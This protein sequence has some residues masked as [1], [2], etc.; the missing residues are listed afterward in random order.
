MK[1]NKVVSIGRKKYSKE[2]ISKMADEFRAYSE[3]CRAQSA[4]NGM[5]KTPIEIKTLDERTII[6][7][8]LG[9]RLEVI[10][11]TPP[12]A[13]WI[14]FCM[15]C[16]NILHIMGQWFGLQAVETSYISLN[17]HN[18]IFPAALAQTDGLL[19]LHDFVMKGNNEPIHLIDII[20]IEK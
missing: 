6:T 7:D 16:T 13:E 17:G 2:E 1:E 20:K 4:N 19:N 9:N 3:Q 15:R 10:M 18:N 14:D 11:E 5:I 12:D 8:P